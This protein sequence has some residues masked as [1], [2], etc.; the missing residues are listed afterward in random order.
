MLFGCGTY[1]GKTHSSDK[2]TLGL[3]P[4]A[5]PL[6]L[7]NSKLRCFPTVKS[8][9]EEFISLMVALCCFPFTAHCT[10]PVAVGEKSGLHEVIMC[11]SV[12]CALARHCRADR[13][14][15][16]ARSCMLQVFAL[17]LWSRLAFSL[18]VSNGVQKHYGCTA[19]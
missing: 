2:L 17:N 11:L 18:C 9:R 15:V 13:L 1:T 4:T 14:Q 3:G 16:G 8:R 19:D 6:C 12:N 5:E 7:S 10:V